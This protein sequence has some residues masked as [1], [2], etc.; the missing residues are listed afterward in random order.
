[1]ATK[2]LKLE[3]EAISEILI[4]DTD[5]ESGVEVSDLEEN[6]KKK[7][8]MSNNNYYYYSKPPQKTNHRL[9]QVV[10]DCHPGDRLKEGRQMFILLS[11][12]QKV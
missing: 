6:L 12:Q 3:E 10:K 4:A 8:K 9:Q 1:M 11:V 7:K 5:S 2:K